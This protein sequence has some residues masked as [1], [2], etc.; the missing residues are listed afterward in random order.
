MKLPM[1]ATRLGILAIKLIVV[2][3]VILSIAP[4]LVGDISIDLTGEGSDWS[5][6]NGVLALNSPLVVEN[7]GFFDLNDVAVEFVLLDQ[8]GEV[9]FRSESDGTDIPAGGSTDLDLS[10]ELDLNDL[11]RDELKDMVF[12]GSD[13]RFEVGISAK[14][15]WDLV[16]GSV[17]ATSDMDWEPMVRD[18]DLRMEEIM[19]LY[20]GMGYYM[21]IPYSF[22]ISDMVDNQPLLVRVTFEDALGNDGEY[23]TVVQ[24]YQYQQGT[25]MVPISME[26]YDRLVSNPENVSASLTIGLLDV[27]K[28]VDESWGWTP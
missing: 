10:I 27:S 21:L 28:T 9:L 14:Y 12:N 26:T 8:N 16:R 18:M 19:P 6:D 2:L 24:T 13:L 5:V 3:I 25:A 4:L 11:S 17:T 23:E 20:D 22:S 15:S 1:L 7:H